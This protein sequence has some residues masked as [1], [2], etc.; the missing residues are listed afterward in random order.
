[1]SNFFIHLQPGQG[2]EN[3][4]I[5]K[6][7]FFFLKRSPKKL[8]SEAFELSTKRSQF[9]DPKQS[10]GGLSHR[11]GEQRRDHHHQHPRLPHPPQGEPEIIIIHR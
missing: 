10:V 3:K 9:L 6:K 8:H 11:D 5:Q 1:M 7:I 4:E 2:G